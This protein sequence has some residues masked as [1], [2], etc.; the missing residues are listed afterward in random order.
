MKQTFI[1][2]DTPGYGNDINWATV[3]Y[4]YQNVFGEVE[5]Q[6]DLRYSVDIFKEYLRNQKNGIF[7]EIGV[8]G[9]ATL[10]GV[11][12]TCEMNNIEIY[13]IDPFENIKIFN[14]ISEENSYQEIVSEV[15]KL[16][17]KRKNNLLKIIN[18]HNLN[19][20]IIQKESWQ[21]YQDFQ[22]N[23]ISCIHI[24]GDHSYEGVKKDLNLFWKK[25]KSGGLVISDDYD[26]KGCSKAIDEFVSENKNDIVMEIKV[27][28]NKHIMF[29]K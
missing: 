23:S 22:D 3:S 14:G 9:G 4:L 20:N 24:D 18:E 7:V 11:Y 27:I 10:L 15:R 29:K 12:K 16:A 26:W 13:G 5:T 2:N 8:F 28:K 21:A 6:C 25:I 17:E 19:I 1:D